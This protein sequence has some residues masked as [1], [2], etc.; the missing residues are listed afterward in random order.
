MTAEKTS[1][2]NDRDAFATTEIS[3]AE[4]SLAD[5]ESSAADSMDDFHFDAADL[6]SFDEVPQVEQ[7]FD[8]TA[9]EKMP[10]ENETVDFSTADNADDFHFDEADLP[11]FDEVPPVQSETSDID[12]ASG[13]HTFSDDFFDGIDMPTEETGSAARNID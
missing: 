6:P 4:K 3:S 12:R 9:A 1:R 10:I 13:D 5:T 8:D 11:S 7:T 2:E